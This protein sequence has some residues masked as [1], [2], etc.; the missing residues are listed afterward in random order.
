METSTGKV[1]AVI[2]PVVD[3]KFTEA[4]L[5]EIYASLELTNPDTNEKLVCEVAQH[6]GDGVVRAI[7]MSSTEGLQR[8]IDVVNTGM[9]ISVPVGGEVLG[10]ILNVLGEPIDNKGPVEAKTTYPIHRS[11]PKFENLSTQKEILETNLD[12]TFTT[13]PM[14]LYWSIRS[15]PMFPAMIL[16]V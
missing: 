10:R 13:S 2:G 12:A 11:V 8:G 7:A 14:A 4:G 1:I 16:P 9:P 5:P 15:L 6:L 3:V